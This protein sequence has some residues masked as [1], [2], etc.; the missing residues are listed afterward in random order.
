[1]ISFACTL[2][3]VIFTIPGESSTEHGCKRRGLYLKY[4]QRRSRL[5]IEEDVGKEM[6]KIALYEGQTVASSDDNDGRLDE[7]EVDEDG[8][9]T[10]KLE[11]RFDKTM[12]VSSCYMIR[13]LISSLGLIRRFT[14]SWVRKFRTILNHATNYIFEL[15]QS[16]FI[17]KKIGLQRMSE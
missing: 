4:I 1:M 9:N 7:D 3:E 13:F 8:L 10:A 16:P 15:F 11:Q 14:V 6:G 12:R 2:F 17:T 5:G